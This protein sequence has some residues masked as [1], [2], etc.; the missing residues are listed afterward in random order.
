MKFSIRLEVQD[1]AGKAMA[2]GGVTLD[3]PSADEI[4]AELSVLGERAIELAMAQA[5]DERAGK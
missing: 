5:E 1:N 4:R 3:N 2:Q